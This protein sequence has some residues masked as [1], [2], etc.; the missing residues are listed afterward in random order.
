MVIGGD[1][2]TGSFAKSI[3]TAGARA[4]GLLVIAASVVFLLVSLLPY[5]PGF[6]GLQALAGNQVVRLAM[7]PVVLLHLLHLWTQRR[8]V[9]GAVVAL[10]LLILASEA[11]LLL[12]LRADEPGPHETRLRIASLNV[13]GA[14]SIN[15]PRHFHDASVDIGCLQEVSARDSSKLALQCHYHQYTMVSTLAY[16]SMDAHL[17]LFSRLPVIDQFLLTLPSAGDTQTEVPGMRIRAGTDTVTVVAVHLATVPRSGP[18]ATRVEAHRLRDRQVDRL[19]EVVDGERGPVI[20]VGDFNQT[21]T[22]AG[23]RRLRSEFED[24]WL[25]GGAGLGATWPKGLPFLRIDYVYSRGMAGAAR[26]KLDAFL[27]TDHML[28]MIDLHRP[29]EE[30]V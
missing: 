14:P 5:L 29:A 17:V 6:G 9:H 12:P 24:A 13:M 1:S 27:P 26:G 8:L 11:F 30:G 4:G 10:P 28:L 19:L 20:L 3:V 16:S 18:W 15:A 2:Q 21:P 7:L 22:E 25:D 23:A